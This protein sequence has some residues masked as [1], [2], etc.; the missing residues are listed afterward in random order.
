MLKRARDKEPLVRIQACMCLLLFLDED[1]DSK[2]EDDDDSDDDFAGGIKQTVTD[3]MIHD[4]SAEVRRAIIG[5]ITCDPTNM[6][7]L[8]ERAR[9][10]DPA[11]RRIMYTRILPILGD[12]RWMTMVA[13]EKLLRWGLRDRDDGVRKGAQNLFRETWLG[14][15]VARRDNR[16]DE[17]KEASIA[18]PNMEALS[19]LLERIDVFKSGDEEGMA[20][21]A[22]RSFWEGRPDYREA[23]VFD[24]DFW[25]NLD[26]N[27]AFIARTFNDYCHSVENANAV[28][29]IEDK[30]PEVTMF[31]YII[32]KNLNRLLDLAQRHE[33]IDQEDPDYSMVTEDLEEQ[34]FQTRQLLHIALTLDYTDEVGRLQMY[35]IMRESISKAYLPE[36]CIKLAIEVLRLMC[37][38]RGEYE[39]CSLI[40]EAIAEVREGVDEDSDDGDA[41]AMDDEEETFHS[42]TSDVARPVPAAS[43]KQAKELSPEEEAERQ[44]KAILAYARCLW[45]AQCMLQNVHGDLDKNSSLNATLNN[46]IVPAV[47]SHD[48]YIRERGVYCLGLTVLLSKVCSSR[49]FS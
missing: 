41:E 37:G 8:L 35:N 23:I 14:F 31:A 19:E 43:K 39:F 5:T 22:M 12:F 6:K 49:S 21:D 36:E 46:L 25:N 27:T 40:A 44:G 30:M 33:S 15:C 26:G 48:V 2:D 4:P 17:E 18:P 3:I 29:M 13:R 34:D 42:A 16:S 24:H 38:S 1:E 47:R 28:D 9:D 10:A 32:L 7:L 45:I 11:I 20:H